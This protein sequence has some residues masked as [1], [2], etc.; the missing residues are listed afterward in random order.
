M[1]KLEVYR[2]SQSI[3]RKRRPHIYEQRVSFVAQFRAVVPK[4]I[5]VVYPLFMIT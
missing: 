3:P 2:F 1:G 5:L 4:L